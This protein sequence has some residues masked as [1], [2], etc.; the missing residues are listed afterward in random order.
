MYRKP[1]RVGERHGQFN[2]AEIRLV[3]RQL[4]NLLMY[5]FG[6]AAPRPNSAVGTVNEADFAQRLITI[7]SAVEGRERNTKAHERPARR[8]EGFF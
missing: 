5:R 6:N 3:Q 7:V 2:R 4:V 1:P 8:Q